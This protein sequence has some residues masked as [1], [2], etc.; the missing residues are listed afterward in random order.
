MLDLRNA[1]DT[2]GNSETRG[3]GLLDRYLFLG[4][5]MTEEFRDV[6]DWP[7]RRGGSSL[8][9]FVLSLDFTQPTRQIYPSASHYAVPR[10]NTHQAS[11]RRTVFSMRSS[12]AR[13]ISVTQM[14]RDLCLV[15]FRLWLCLNKG[16]ALNLQYIDIGKWWDWGFLILWQA[17]DIKKGCKTLNKT[18]TAA[19]NSEIST[20]FR[21]CWISPWCFQMLCSDFQSSICGDE[22]AQIQHRTRPVTQKKTYH[23]ARSRPQHCKIQTWVFRLVRFLAFRKCGLES[24][25]IPKQS[26][27]IE[28]RTTRRSRLGKASPRIKS[29]CGHG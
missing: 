25:R 21:R 9:D 23:S 19:E 2:T 18:R 29:G 12:A 4:R 7:W 27:N 6:E 13:D 16:H 26:E 14:L 8:G 3:C 24:L 15:G 10:Q 28:P 5:K 11:T 20:L 22:M 17:H 1:G